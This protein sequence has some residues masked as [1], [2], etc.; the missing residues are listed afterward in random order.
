MAQII[1]SSMKV[2]GAV[3]VIHHRQD[4]TIKAA[5]YNQKEKKETILQSWE[6]AEHW[7]NRQ[8]TTGN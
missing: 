8:I 3:A 1:A 4:E 6:Q 5:I 7:I 2:N